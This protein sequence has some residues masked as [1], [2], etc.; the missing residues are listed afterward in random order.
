[1]K[2]LKKILGLGAMLTAIAGLG[3][4]SACNDEKPGI[5]NDDPTSFVYRVSLQN[6]TGFGFSGAT[7][8]LMKGDEVVATKTTNRAGN[9]NFQE[10]DVKEGAYEIVVEGAPKGY[11]FSNPDRKY[12]TGSKGTSTVVSITPTGVLEDAAPMGTYYK[13]GDVVHDFTVKLPNGDDYT[14]SK[15]LEEKKMVLLNFWATWCDPCKSEFPAM[16]NAAIEY[17]DTVSVIAVSTTDSQ[18][19][20]QEFQAKNGYTQFNMAASGSDNLKS[21][22]G[23]QGIPHTVMIDRYGVI[24]FNEVGGMPSV[25]AFTSRFERFVGD[26]YL[27]T[28][29]GSSAEEETPGGSTEAERMEPN[30]SAPNV[31]ELKSVLTQADFKFRFQEEDVMAGEEGYDKY[32]WPWVISEDKSYIYASNKNINNSYAILYSTMTAK[33]GDV[34]VFD[35]KIGSELN[36]DIFYVMLDGA[37]ISQYSGD[38]AKD[39]QT[40]YSYVFKDYEAGEHEVAFVFLKDS[41]TMANEDIVQMKNLRIEQ[42]DSLTSSTKDINIFRQAATNPNTDKD[43]TTQFKNYVNV[44]YNDKD[45]YY[46][47]GDANGPVLYANMLNPSVWNENGLWLLAYNNYIVGDGM[48]F[49]D[50]IEEYAWEASQVTAVNG[51]TPVTED[52]RYLL[53]AAARY[54]SF[55]EKFYGKYQDEMEP[56]DYH[57]NEWLELCVYWEHYGTAPMPKDPMA[58][59]TFTAAIPLTA[60]TVDAPVANPVSVPYKIN[61]RGFKY[62]FIPEKS[63]AYRVYSKGTADSIVFLVAGD[64]TTQIGYYDNNIFADEKDDNFDFYHYF[65][66]GETYY[67][68]FTTYL[69]NFAEYDVYIDYLAESYTFKDNAAVGPYSAN[70]N[71]FELFLPDAIAYEYAD[72]AKT[73]LY[74][75]ETVERAG[76]GVYH[77]K[78]ED[79]TLGGV[80]YLDLDRNT[81]FFNSA[82]L[83]SIC[84]DAVKKDDNGEFIYPP[85]KRALYVEEQY[86]D[87]KY[88]AAKDYTSTFQGWWFEA[89]K[90]TGDM[91]GF[92]AVTKEIYETLQILTR[93]SKYE[94]I[95]ETWLLLCYYDRTLSAN[96]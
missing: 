77:H 71:T 93:S 66:A 78:K 11:E 14:L 7:V 12:E 16:H 25:S 29:L 51:Y 76:D 88:V 79:G 22:F 24:V 59:I 38:N 48:N 49:R 55:G 46:H 4:I 1:M 67:M 19:G 30:V 28:V 69:D 86:I 83:H 50:A 54:T 65:K 15:V 35:Y 42:V 8:K 68:L 5:G 74:A 41:A 56:L 31:N 90:H 82:S 44:V 81:P 80:I 37:I 70:L 85:E 52:L 47:V 17:K 3:V 36:S 73:Y 62:K 6:E 63:G 61:P 84:V 9:A 27:P 23:V 75:G 2:L 40:S 53:D 39:W 32:N 96:E 20:V 18:E 89:S 87:G 95:E 60:G 92:M 21:F 94:G 33:A 91:K 13:L 34:L 45:E 26:D 58:A 72:P 43:A 57:E 64:R 10:G